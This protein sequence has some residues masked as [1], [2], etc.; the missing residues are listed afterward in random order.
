VQMGLLKNK[1]CT[2]SSWGRG[3]I[4]TL[5]NKGIFPGSRERGGKPTIFNVLS[6]RT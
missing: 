2:V 6:P 4:R 5:I 3:W 1:H